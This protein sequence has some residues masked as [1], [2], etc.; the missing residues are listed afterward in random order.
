MNAIAHLLRSCE[1]LRGAAIL[2]AAGFFALLSPVAHADHFYA[3]QITAR[4]LGTSL[5]T[6]F[7]D[8]NDILG[9]PSG[10]PGGSTHV[11]NLGVGG[12]I[13]LG[14]NTAD[15]TRTITNGAGADFIVF[16]NAFYANS[17]TTKSFAELVFVEV[18]SNGTDFARFPTL[19]LTPSGVGGFGTINPANVSGF[20]G[21]HEVLANVNTNSI[22]P[23]DPELAGGDA[24]DLST[25]GSN[26]L[27]LGGQVDLNAIRYVR[28]ID[29]LGDGTVLDSSNN[30]IYDPTGFGSG[31]SDIDSVAVIHG[32]SVT[33]EPGVS[34]VALTGI[35]WALSRRKRKFNNIDTE[36]QRKQYCPLLFSVPPRLG[37]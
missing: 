14:F 18:S 7:Q 22:D 4:T 34:T 36:A 31:G 15:A 19:S 21:V 33:P 27:V 5:Q 28:L 10:N 23:F 16:E 8:T 17:D 26:T 3:S 2:A 1:V 6:G 12:Q 37:D 25:L 20:A 11:L 30:P 35:G 24:F 32:V 29:V 13:T 9:G